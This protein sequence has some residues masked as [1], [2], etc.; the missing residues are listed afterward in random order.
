MKIIEYIEGNKMVLI[1][2]SEKKFMPV[3]RKDKNINTVAIKLID[4][5]FQ[6]L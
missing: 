5:L 2:Q 1:V 3:N 6:Y 4:I